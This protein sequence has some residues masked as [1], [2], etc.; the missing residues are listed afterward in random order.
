MKKV[1][2]LT[3]SDLVKI[4]RK[5][6]SEE[7]KIVTDHDKSFD[8][9][10]DGDKY[11]FKG[12]GKLKSKYPDWTLAD[13]KDAMEAIKTKVFKDFKEKKDVT[14][15]EVA[16]NAKKIEKT[17]ETK[18]EKEKPKEP[19]VKSKKGTPEEVIKFLVDKGL[20]ESQAAGVAGNLHH[21]SGINPTVKPGDKGTSFGIA[22][23]H[24]ERGER[25]KSWTKQNGHDSNSLNGQLEYLWW[26][27]NNT[28][29]RALSKLKETDDPKDAAFMFAKYF[30][31][32]ASCQNRSRVS[33]RLAT[34]QK[35]Y[36]NY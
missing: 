30:E 2:R 28:E 11:Y 25:M 21:E 35:F 36:D 15:E 6:I 4:V 32:C 26:E 13:N 14:P 20:T 17:I 1:I 19:E 7:T 34:A 24:K 9:K 16:K 10:K 33:N 18:Y 27:L 12:K 5:I 29:K 8:Y 23:W 3:E 31:R 22:Q